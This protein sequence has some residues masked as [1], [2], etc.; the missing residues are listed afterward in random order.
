MV[1]ELP[2]EIE[3]G[4]IELE[5]GET[6]SYTA[7]GVRYRFGHVNWKVADIAFRKKSDAEKWIKEHILRTEGMEAEVV[8]VKRN[9]L[10]NKDGNI[11]AWTEGLP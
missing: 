2:E 9:L 11:T 4:T 7:W 3:I 5:P 1:N 6:F 10:L 8:P